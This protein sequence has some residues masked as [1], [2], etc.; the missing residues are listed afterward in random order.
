MSEH[1]LTP[2]TGPNFAREHQLAGSVSSGRGIAELFSEL[3]GDFDA[4]LL[5]PKFLDILDE[6]LA[7]APSP[8]TGA[9]VEI[10]LSS[11]SA[12][13]PPDL[14]CGYR[15]SRGASLTFAESRTASCRP[16]TRASTLPLGALARHW[17]DPEHPFGRSAELV[18]IEFDYFDHDYIHD[19]GE[20][21]GVGLHLCVDERL[22]HSGLEHPAPQPRASALELVRQAQNC[23][24]LRVPGIDLAGYVD[25][26][27]RHL[28]ETARIVHVSSMF[29]RTGH[30]IKL[31]LW[32]PGPAAVQNL[33]ESTGWQGDMHALLTLMAPTADD[34]PGQLGIKIDL[35]AQPNHP[36]ALF[37]PRVGIEWARHEHD[38][39]SWSALLTRFESMGSC[40]PEQRHA[41]QAWPGRRRIASS[42]PEASVSIERDLVFKFVLG[43]GGPQLKAYLALRCVPNLF[44]T[45]HPPE[46][47]GAGR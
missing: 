35:A 38:P 17:G 10:R 15:R 12:V 23:G 37:G 24:V 7:A 36:N 4:R 34:A 31:N 20:L 9:F 14:L 47:R 2:S 44:P 27:E 28:P 13:T 11:Q 30:P 40:S 25:L 45:V 32:L 21:R 5:S 22:A 41:L 33:L 19:H 42:A 26:V 8:V 29:G 39:H 18:L 43:P 1:P 6:G 16:C 46:P 3:R